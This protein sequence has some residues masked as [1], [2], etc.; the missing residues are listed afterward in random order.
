MKGYV[1]NLAKDTKRL[2]SARALLHK[3]GIEP[4]RVPAIDGA[5]VPNNRLSDGEVGCYHSHALALQMF[6]RSQEPA[7]IVFEDD[8]ASDLSKT[9]FETKMRQAREH[10]GNF[11]IVYLGKCYCEC[12]TFA[13]VDHDL[14]ST[15]GALCLHAY[16]VSRTG[17]QKLL[18]LVEK[19]V[20]TDPIDLVYYNNSMT[21]KI[22][23]GAFHPS[24]FTQ[25][26]ET[27]Q[28]NLRSTWQANLNLSNE[29]ARLHHAVKI[30]SPL[31]YL[32]YLIK[33]YW[34]V[35][36]LV[37]FSLYLWIRNR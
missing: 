13:K 29:C 17:A 6:L 5:L 35:L 36:T 33:E 11:D 7:G 25:D 22:R 26:A 9:Q 3:L 4:V 15:S 10:L 30:R 8:V 1:I 37:M 12:G 34:W 21:G 32:W 16:M 24:L 2:K 27:H 18:N 19:R 28:S 31:L 20:P 23:A 14:Y